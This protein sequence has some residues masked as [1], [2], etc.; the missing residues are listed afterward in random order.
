[1]MMA[2]FSAAISSYFVLGL[3]STRTVTS[4]C[5]LNGVDIEFYEDSA[6]TQKISV[7]NWKIVKEDEKFIKTLYLKNSGEAPIILN[8]KVSENIPSDLKDLISMSWDMEG[9]S[10]P[11]GE[12]TPAVFSF[13]LNKLIQGIEEIGYNVTVSNIE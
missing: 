9:V 4:M 11:P 1:M 5:N 8:M 10:L 13:T 12:S 7:L 2:I 6:C 3:L